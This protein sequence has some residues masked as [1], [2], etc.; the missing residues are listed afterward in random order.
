MKKTP[1]DI[2]YDEDGLGPLI[3]EFGRRGLGDD[4]DPDRPSDARSSQVILV[5]AGLVLFGIFLG[6]AK[7]H[8]GW[9]PSPPVVRACLGLWTAI[10]IAATTLIRRHDARMV[11]LALHEQGFRYLGSPFRFVDIQAIRF[12]RPSSLLERML[13]AGNRGFGAFRTASAGAADALLAYR[14]GS[15]RVVLNTGDEHIL[16]GF[17]VVVRPEVAR[18]FFDLMESRRPGIIE[19]PGR[20][21]WGMAS[22]TA[23]MRL[24]KAWGGSKGTG[25]ADLAAARTSAAGAGRPLSP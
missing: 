14:E 22:E 4:Y 20:S 6:L 19:W 12:G 13:Y 5:V 1:I 15:V 17:R 24:R 3:R 16:N 9:A 2:V 25:P 21:D 10:L 8:A 23:R 11:V 7:K 18:R